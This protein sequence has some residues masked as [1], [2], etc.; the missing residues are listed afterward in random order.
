MCVI[1][2]YFV[3]L[4]VSE[5]LFRVSVSYF[6]WVGVGGALFFVGEGEWGWVHCL[7]MSIWKIFFWI[8]YT[9]ELISRDLRKWNKNKIRE[10]R[11]IFCN[12]AWCDVRY[13]FIF[14]CLLKLVMA[15]VFLPTNFLHRPCLIQCNAN[16]TSL[17]QASKSRNSK[18]W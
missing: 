8:Y 3:W 1:G 15:R 10:T 13:Y 5:A 2:L 16:N 17:V 9:L 7:T 4:A 18:R 11:E 12:I 6:G 14:K